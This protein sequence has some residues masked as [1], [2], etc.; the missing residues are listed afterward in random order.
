MG[1]QFSRS[2]QCDAAAE[3][4]NAILK[5]INGNMTSGLQDVIVLLY[6]AAVRLDLDYCIQFWIWG[7]H[8]TKDEDR[9]ESRCRGQ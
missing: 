6:T 9:M 4:A 5:G 1:H 7:S 3:K 8:F 2:S